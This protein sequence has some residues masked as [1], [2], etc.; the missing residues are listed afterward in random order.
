M[1]RIG[2]CFDDSPRHPLALHFIATLCVPVLN[3]TPIHPKLRIAR[4]FSIEYFLQIGFVQELCKV[5][6]IKIPNKIWFRRKVVSLRML[7][8]ASFEGAFN[9]I[10]SKVVRSRELATPQQDLRL[11]S[12]ALCQMF[13]ICPIHRI[14]QTSKLDKPGLD[15]RSPSFRN[16]PSGGSPPT[17]QSA[18]APSGCFQRN[19][20]TRTADNLLPR[21]RKPFPRGRPHRLQ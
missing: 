17:W 8:K 4:L 9:G 5:V 3:D 20:R 16:S 1:L 10:A 13:E 19:S 12:P 21:R 2:N 7:G 14:H 11:F 15:A 18:P 6:S